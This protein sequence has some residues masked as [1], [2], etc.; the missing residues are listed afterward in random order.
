MA[1]TTLLLKLKHIH[2]VCWW[3]RDGHPAFNNANGDDLILRKDVEALLSAANTAQVPADQVTDARKQIIEAAAALAHLP[4]EDDA[5][6]EQMLVQV[7][8][9]ASAIDLLSLAPDTAA[10]RNDVLKLR[11]LIGDDGFATGFQSLGQYR[12]NLLS[13]IDRC[14]LD[15]PSPARE[16]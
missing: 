16:K 3:H 6:H 7:R 10:I 15:A 9:I 4:I 11:A 5:M 8:K 13:F 2:T 14:I 1:D 12:T